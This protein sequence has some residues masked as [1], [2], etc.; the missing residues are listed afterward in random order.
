MKKILSVEP[1][2]L[3]EPAAGNE[4]LQT[5]FWGNFKE[6][7]GWKAQAFHCIYSKQPFKL[8]VLTRALKIGL[9]LAYI[10][11]GPC[12]KPG[13][14]LE[15]ASPMEQ[16][17]DRTG[18]RFLAA[19]ARA[20]RPFLPEGT[21]FILL[22]PASGLLKAPVDIQ[23]PSTVL[24]D[25][26]RT[27]DE[28][29]A[30]M[31]SKTR[32]NIRLALKKGVRVEE[33]SFKDLKDWYE[34][35]RETARRDRI[36]L[37]SFNYYRALFDPAGAA[38]ADGAESGGPVIR[39]LLARAG[40][41]GELLAGIIIAFW[42]RGSRYLYGASS[43]RKRNLMPAYALQWRAIRLAKER[44]CTHYDL[45][46]IPPSDDPTHPMHGLYRFKTGFGGEIFN[47]LG[48]YDFAFKS[49]RYRIY[50]A[51]EAGRNLYYHRIRKRRLKRENG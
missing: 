14:P 35:Y 29:L 18:E 27:E 48:C 50:R 5:A 44:G 25:L 49:F 45:F 2:G 16:V 8:L 10:P 51:A 20:L 26:K 42:E 46:G 41:K 7:F 34:L 23:P 36:T 15:T 38:G 31:K 13:R 12:F 32:Y 22:D 37:H 11:H 24:I 30:G 40:L 47:R 9:K 43:S 39:L 1:A 28:I 3:E 21:V 4:L 19:L 33:G 6:Q 17:T